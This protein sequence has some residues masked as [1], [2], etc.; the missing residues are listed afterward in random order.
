M[1]KLSFAGQE[2]AAPFPPSN[3]PSFVLYLRV[4][5]LLF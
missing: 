1:Y 4:M 2:K 5:P 3:F